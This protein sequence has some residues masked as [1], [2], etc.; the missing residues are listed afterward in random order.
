MQ[1]TDYHNHEQNFLRKKIY[2]ANGK[3]YLTRVNL[4]P[5]TRW[6]QLCLH[7]FHQADSTSSPYHDHPYDF[8]S[9]VLWGWYIETFLRFIDDGPPRY[10]VYNRPEL[11]QRARRWLSFRRVRTEHA[12]KI[13]FVHLWISLPCITLMWRSPDRREWYLYTDD[14]QK[15]LGNPKGRP[16]DSSPT[17]RLRHD[18]PH[19]QIIRR[20]TAESRAI[21]KAFQNMFRRNHNG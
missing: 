13:R 11:V 7:I 2:L 14:G 15:I 19:V 1:L 9:I 18:T 5:M 10:H 16:L 4:T 3:P 6:G 17:G 21:R 8:W 20:S 12:H